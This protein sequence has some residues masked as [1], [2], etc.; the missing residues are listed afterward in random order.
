MTTNRETPISDKSIFFLENLTRRKV[1]IGHLLWSIRES[2]EMTQVKFAKKLEVSRQYLCDLEHNRR[3]VSAKAAA[4]FALRLG[5]S[6]IHFI[7]IAM[8]DEL[9][10]Y[11]FNLDVQITEHKDAA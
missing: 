9:N 6:P 4:D 1:T 7:Q 2:E 10:K 11:G 5:Y 8:Q 3:I